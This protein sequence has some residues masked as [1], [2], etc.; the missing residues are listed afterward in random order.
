MFAA[1]VWTACCS[2]GALGP[3]DLSDVWKLLTA[4]LTRSADAAVVARGALAWGLARNAVRVIWNAVSSG[5]IPPH[6]C[7]RLT[8]PNAGL[9]GVSASA[10][11]G[12]S[13]DVTPLLD[14]APLWRSAV[15][16]L[17]LLDAVGRQK[18]EEYFGQGVPAGVFAAAYVV[19]YAAVYHD[20]RI[21]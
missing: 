16:L 21:A 2:T 9:N 19:V 1:D 3:A 18:I 10:G 8:D 11:E 4:L 17:D 6:A 20:L 7:G 15:V 5:W 12:S 14:W 13:D